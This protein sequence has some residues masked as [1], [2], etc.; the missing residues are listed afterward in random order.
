MKHGERGVACLLPS[1]P[2]D[3]LTSGGVDGLMSV[4]QQVISV[5]MRVQCVYVWFLVY[6]RRVVVQCDGF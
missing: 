3:E 5:H 2:E 1:Y 4:W 6:R